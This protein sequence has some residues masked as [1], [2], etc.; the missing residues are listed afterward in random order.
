MWRCAVLTLAVFRM[1]SLNDLS[2]IM[3]IFDSFGSCLWIPGADNIGS[4]YNQLCWQTNHSSFKKRHNNIHKLR[5]VC[6][7]TIIIIS[8]VPFF[9]TNS[10][11]Y[12]LIYLLISWAHSTTKIS[13]LYSHM[14]NFYSIHK[15]LK[16]HSS[17]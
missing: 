8:S 17:N 12:Q 7:I 15:G 10:L 2:T 13:I 4:R 11:Q 6:N 1:T 3:K 14:Y 9:Q 5:N 16:K